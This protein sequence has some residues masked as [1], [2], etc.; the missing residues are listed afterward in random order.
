M[1]DLMEKIAGGQDCPDTLRISRAA[2]RPAGT[3]IPGKGAFVSTGTG[4]EG[5]AGVGE[6]TGSTG[7]RV[8]E[9]VVAIPA[10]IWTR[11]V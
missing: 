7:V 9:A 1:L 10:A 11:L 8:I 3:R 2:A 6:D 5:C 4:V